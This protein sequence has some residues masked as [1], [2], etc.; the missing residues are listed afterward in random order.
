[1]SNK[2]TSVVTMLIAVLLGVGALLAAVLYGFHIALSK[3]EEDPALAAIERLPPVERNIALNK[4]NEERALAAKVLAEAQANQKRRSSACYAARVAVERKLKTPS[5]AKFPSCLSGDIG[6]TL[7][8]KDGLIHVSGYVDS[9]N[10]YGAMLRAQFLVK[11]TEF[12]G[13]YI[14]TE[15]KIR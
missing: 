10:S 7:K 8:G 5:T 1:M 11:M 9:Q 6:V 2:G 3:G 4:L 12:D 14:P 13:G 15:V